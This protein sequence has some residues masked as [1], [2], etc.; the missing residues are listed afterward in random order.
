MHAVRIRTPEMSLVD[1]QVEA[2]PVFKG[3]LR[4]TGTVSDYLDERGARVVVL[5]HGQNAIITVTAEEQPLP[6]APP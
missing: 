4:V 2:D 6:E 5:V 1:C 3:M